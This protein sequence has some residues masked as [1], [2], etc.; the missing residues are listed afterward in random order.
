M[1][2]SPG[3]GAGVVRVRVRGIYATA[4]TR[5][6]LDN[7]FQ[8][9]QA[10][11]VI[12]DRFG[13][14]ILELP[15]D[16]TLKNSDRE[17]SELVVV[18]YTWA[19]ERV[20]ERLRGTLPYSFYWV[21]SLPLHATVKA[22]AGQGC[23][24]RVGDV[25]A[26]L[27][28]EN[29]PEPGTQLVAGVVRPGVK[30]GEKP[31]LAPG[32]RV[33]GDYAILYE[34][35]KPRTTVSEHI[36]S[37][38]KRAELMAIA[39]PYLEKGL[40]V[41][42]RSSARHASRETLE[43]HLSQLSQ[44]LN[45]VKREAE[46]GPQGVYSTGETVA[47]VRLSRPDKEAL[48]E[49]RA[50]VVPTAAW[51]HSV[52]SV[53]PQAGIVVD[54]EEK[55]LQHGLQRE[56]LHEAL[57]DLYAERLQQARTV[58]IHHVKP[59]STTV[60]LGPAT[61]LQ[62]ERRGP[63][64]IILLER[65][66]RSRGVYDGLGVEKEPGDRILTEVDTGSWVTVHRYY[67]RDGELKGVYYNINTPPELSG[68]TITYLDLEADVVRKPGEKPRPVDLEEAMQAAETRVITGRMLE[69]ILDI[70]GSLTGEEAADTRAGSPGD[71]EANH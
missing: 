1:A 61:V 68:D 35:G 31:R 2:A 54:Y 46:Q 42:W 20:L 57:L 19:A 22:E 38:E 49:I 24:A 34:T 4:L 47:V 5:W 40:G 17:P 33:I 41:H 43:Q 66:V 23:T 45:E 30:P 3:S 16:V 65:R 36:R 29:C 27:V 11:R 48:D 37:P 62:V 50:R 69:K 6:A 8:V 60:T 21:S 18:G 58:R 28:E 14:P 63:R 25:E 44:L 67:N 70:V 56:R 52:K 32:A 12:A 55:L 7:G 9:V 39:A 15:A 64:L 26:E 53:D 51:H 59:D 71:G 13:I 10:S